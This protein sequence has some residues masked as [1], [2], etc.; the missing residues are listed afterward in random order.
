[1]S[2]Q[3]RIARDLVFAGYANQSANIKGNAMMEKVYLHDHFIA[4]PDEQDWVEEASNG[5]TIAQAA[6][7]GGTVTI[8]T[9]GT[10][11]DVGEFS[12]AAQ[13]S[14]SKNCVMEARVKVDD[15]TTVGLNVG[16]IDADMSANDQICYELDG[17]NALV[18]ARG[19]DGAA[20]VFD[21][22]AGTDV[23]YCAAVKSD[24]EGTP[25]TLAGGT[26]GATTAPVNNT[27]AN[28]RVAL[29]TS[30]NATFYYNGEAVGY[31]PECCT[32]AT[33]MCPYVAIVARDGVARVATI[34]RI[35]C[36]QD[37]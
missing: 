5:S 19:S 21:T 33:L 36:W 3:V 15:I 9:G 22:D 16:W 34:D 13:W 1:M 28:F 37:E 35:T 32:A 29:D 26:Y 12:H 4:D 31:L 14:G 23:W 24:T 10:D 20:F 17:T 8:T 6:A 18:N 11:D 7:N 30:G 27:Y 2:Q 25:V